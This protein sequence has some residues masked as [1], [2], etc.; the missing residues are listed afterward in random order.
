MQKEIPAFNEGCLT[1]TGKRISPIPVETGS[2]LWF[3][4]AEWGVDLFHTVIHATILDLCPKTCAQVFCS[5]LHVLLSWKTQQQ[6]HLGMKARKGVLSLS[7]DWFSSLR[8]IQDDIPKENPT[9]LKAAWSHRPWI[10]GNLWWSMSYC[11]T[12]WYSW[13]CCALS[14]SSLPQEGKMRREYQHHLI[15]STMSVSLWLWTCKDTALFWSMSYSLAT[16]GKQLPL[17]THLIAFHTKNSL[18]CTIWGKYKPATYL[19]SI[20]KSIFL[21]PVVWGLPNTEQF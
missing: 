1:Q 3:K 21:T 16:D 13:T 12:I 10:I 6:Q 8:C 2:L 15:S 20:L 18:S 7:S 9:A 19:C 17:V 11:N 4:Q 5:K 14:P